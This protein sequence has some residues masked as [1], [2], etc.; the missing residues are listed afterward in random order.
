[1]RPVLDSMQELTRIWMVPTGDLRSRMLLLLG[2]NAHASLD[3]RGWNS[4]RI[5]EQLAQL[6]GTYPGE[7]VLVLTTAQIC[8]LASGLALCIGTEAFAAAAAGGVVC[9]DYPSGKNPATR[10][11]LVGVGLDWVPPWNGGRASKYPGGPGSA[12]K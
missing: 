9:L 11:S 2:P 4:E 6:A 5:E 1:M 7:Q 3:A 10:P 12:A 8:Q